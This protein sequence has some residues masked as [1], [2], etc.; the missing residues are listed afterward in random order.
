MGGRGGLRRCPGCGPCLRPLASQGAAAAS[1]RQPNGT[2]DGSARHSDA[3]VPPSGPQNDPTTAVVSAAAAAAAAAHVAVLVSETLLHRTAAVAAAV[4]ISESVRHTAAVGAGAADGTAAAAAPAVLV[5]RLRSPTPA[6]NGPPDDLATPDGPIGPPTSAEGA[7]LHYPAAAGGGKARPSSPAAGRCAS[8]SPRKRSPTGAQKPHAPAPG[9]RKSTRIVYKGLPETG[10]P[11]SPTAA[12]SDPPPAT[13]RP[14]AAAVS[15]GTWLS[16]APSSGRLRSLS[17]GPEQPLTARTVAAEVGL[18]R[19]PPT[20]PPEGGAP[21][22]RW[23]RTTSPRPRVKT[24]S[25]TGTVS[26]TVAPA[27][28]R[29]RGEAQAESLPNAR[30]AWVE[31]AGWPWKSPSPVCGPTSSPMS[32]RRTQPV[33][34]SDTSSRRLMATPPQNKRASSTVPRTGS[35]RNSI[36]RCPA[37]SQPSRSRASE[38]PPR[39]L[40]PVHF[41]VH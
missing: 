8:P 12:R 15:E 19:A 4:V 39:V 7:A 28:V 20:T 23:V 25:V 35:I 18:P 14:S 2:P 3:A 10:T 38:E 34:G 30:E 29:P 26:G 24:G 31:D 37:R 1:A 22:V 33:L 9:V 5:P 27:C 16:W 21:R 41:H 32:V 17:R 6:L 36:D 40:P 11:L 13:V